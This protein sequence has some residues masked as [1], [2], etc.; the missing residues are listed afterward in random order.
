MAKKAPAT[1]KILVTLKRSVIK[2][3]PAKVRTVR[4]LGLRKV[5]SSRVKDATPAVLGMVAAVAHLVEVKE[6]E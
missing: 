2:Q 6:I 4:S 5:G 3:L 1:K